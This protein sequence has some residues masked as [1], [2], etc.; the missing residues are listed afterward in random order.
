MY[1]AL[2]KDEMS[3]NLV[4]FDLQGH[5]I[6]GAEVISAKRGTLGARIAR[7]VG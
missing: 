4:N 6:A 7:V 1:S 2:V 3:E 5:I